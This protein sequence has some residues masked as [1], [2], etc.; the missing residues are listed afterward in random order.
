MQPVACQFDMPVVLAAIAG[1]F[2][3]VAI[4]VIYAVTEVLIKG[5]IDV[6]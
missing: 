1:F 4:F 2:T 5:S 3:Q 6:N